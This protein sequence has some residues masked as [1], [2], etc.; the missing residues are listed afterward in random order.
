MVQRTMRLNSFDL[1]Y[2]T[3]EYTGKYKDFMEFLN[4]T[5]LLL[6]VQKIFFLT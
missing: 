6:F 3:Y 4:A 2:D 1:K 5:L